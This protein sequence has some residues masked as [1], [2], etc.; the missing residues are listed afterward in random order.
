MTLQNCKIHIYYY[1]LFLLF[2]FAGCAN[3]AVEPYEACRST[4][5]T[6]SAVSRVPYFADDDYGSL[7]EA[8]SKSIASLRSRPQGE[9]IQACGRQFTIGQQLE[10]L[11]KFQ[12][13]LSSSDALNESV[14]DSFTICEV[15]NSQGSPELLATGYYQPRFK[16]SRIYNPPFIYPLYK[17]PADLLKYAEKNEVGSTNRVGRLSNGEHV[18]YWTRQEIETQGLLNGQELLYLADPVDAFVLHVQG[19]ALV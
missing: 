13:F 12:K 1:A 15:L 3:V 6:P 5:V 19:S 4:V 10:T 16:G 18:P 11:L 7:N 14:W 17:R 2:V 9:K 8:L